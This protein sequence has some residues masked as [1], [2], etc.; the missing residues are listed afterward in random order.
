MAADSTLTFTSISL[1][2]ENM[3]ETNVTVVEWGLFA[4]SFTGISQEMWNPSPVGGSGGGG[5]S[6]RPTGG[7]L[8]PRGQS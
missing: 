5:G 2:G 8:Y 7:F 3:D 4:V 6:T 1:P